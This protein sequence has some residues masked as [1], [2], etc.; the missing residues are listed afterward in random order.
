M[1]TSTTIRRAAR[2]NDSTW[3]LVPRTRP[4]GAG[5][6]HGRLAVN[7]FIPRVSMKNLKIQTFAIGAKINGMKKIGFKTSGAPN[8]IGSFT[9]KKVGTTEA[10]PI[11]RLRFDFVNHMNMNGT[12]SVAPVPPMVTINICVPEVRILSACIPCWRRFKLTS[13]FA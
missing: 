12:T 13:A 2:M 4:S 7:E 3:K 10:R 6:V 11:A 8:K 9:P 1:T 5:V